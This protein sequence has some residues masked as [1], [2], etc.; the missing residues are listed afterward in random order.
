MFKTVSVG[1]GT[2]PVFCERVAWSDKPTENYQS[3]LL[4]LSDVGPVLT[5]FSSFILFYG[6]QF[7]FFGS[8]SAVI[9]LNVRR[10]TS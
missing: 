8:L 10:S 2:D 1:I 5:S 9:K 6:P 3:V 7:Y 4:F